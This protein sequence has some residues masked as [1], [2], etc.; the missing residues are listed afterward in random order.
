MLKPGRILHTRLTFIWSWFDRPSL[1]VRSLSFWRALTA[2]CISSF[3]YVL[4]SS[5]I[6]R[7]SSMSSSTL[8]SSSPD[9]LHLLHIQVDNIH[10]VR[11]KWSFCLEAGE[12]KPQLK[13]PCCQGKLFSLIP[14]SRSVAQRELKIYHPSFTLKVYCVL[15]S[16]YTFKSK[17]KVYL[18]VL[19]FSLKV[20]CGLSSG[21]AMLTLTTIF[22]PVSGAHIS[23]AVSLATALIRR[24]SP[25]RALGEQ[26]I[27]ISDS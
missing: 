15:S 4:L 1:H 11:G 22:L 21:L 16:Q 5:G 6:T 14:L 10:S 9:P 18:G 20:Y 23:P 8:S 13:A 12:L 27:S 2:E 7:T 17:I 26:N 25:A 3:F 24:V 19:S